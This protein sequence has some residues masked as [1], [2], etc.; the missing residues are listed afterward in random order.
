MLPFVEQQLD[1]G[2]CLLLLDALDEVPQDY[3]LELTEKLKRFT[4]LST[5]PII[6]TSRIVGYY[7]A[8]IP[9]AKEVEIVPFRQKQ[10]EVYIQK[11]SKISS[12]S[13]YTR[14]DNR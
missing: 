3:R 7:G 11:W 13:I 12:Y 4:D 10:T 1:A 2:Q 6:L 14:D 9:K 8:P 5:C